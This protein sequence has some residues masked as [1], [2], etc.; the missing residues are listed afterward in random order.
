MRA[1]PD[2]KSYYHELFLRGRP[3]LAQAIT[4]LVNPGRR[5]PDPKG[6]PNFYEISRRYALPPDPRCEQDD[7]D[8][9]AGEEQPR[10]HAERSYNPEQYANYSAQEPVQHT[11]PPSHKQRHS[12]PPNAMHGYPPFYGYGHYPPAQ[13]P[14]YPPPYPYQYPHGPYDPYS[15]HHFPN[16]Y[17]SPERHQF[18]NCNHPY[19]HHYPSEQVNM[20]SPHHQ[21]SRLHAPLIHSPASAKRDHGQELSAGGNQQYEQYDA[22]TT[23]PAAAASAYHYPVE[24]S[25]DRYSEYENVTHRSEHS[26]STQELRGYPSELDERKPR[27]APPATTMPIRELEHGT[28]SRGC[29]LAEAFDRHHSSGSPAELD[30]RKP[31]ARADSFTAHTGMLMSPSRG[32]DRRFEWS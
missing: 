3:D 13:Y 30:E 2:H 28:Y 25:R 23:A 19:Y 32:F 1:G 17:S 15:N 31:P 9:N 12:F 8:D 7:S 18:A 29:N 22:Y 24:E 4:R 16:P 20:R 14:H 26:R 5:I 6:E 27:S 11:P 21:S 10:Q